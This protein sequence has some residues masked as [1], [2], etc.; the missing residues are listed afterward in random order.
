M[1]DIKFKEGAKIVYIHDETQDNILWGSSFLFLLL[2]LTK[3]DPSAYYLN[4]IISMVGSFLVM[5][6]VTIY[7][8]M[9]FLE[10]NKEH[11]DFEKDPK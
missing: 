3:L 11:I 5:Q 9:K 7:R 1:K 6:L 2:L 4:P 8:N 10:I